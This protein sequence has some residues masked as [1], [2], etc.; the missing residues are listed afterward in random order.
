MRSSSCCKFQVHVYSNPSCGTHIVEFNR[1]SGDG[2]AFRTVWNEVR[3]QMDPKHSSSSDGMPGVTEAFSV[4]P[5]PCQAPPLTDSCATEALKSIIQMCKSTTME[6]QVEGSHML[7]QLSSLH[8]LQQLLCDTG[9]VQV[10]VEL[11]S[12]EWEIARQ[13]AIFALANLSDL[14]MCQSLIIESGIV[15][16]LVKL[17]TDGTYYTAEL[18]REGA[19]I[20]ANVCS[21]LAAQVVAVGGPGPIATWLQSI[22][23]LKDSRVKYHAG[24]AKQ[25]LMR[26]MAVQTA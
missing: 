20:I 18:R 5:L 16:E 24:R 17:A 11:Q 1:L 21:R 2:S 13:N 25:S 23:T 14:P 3:S 8:D 22:D 7:C 4:A 12:S 10:L 6:S 19:R 15:L 26:A 9:C